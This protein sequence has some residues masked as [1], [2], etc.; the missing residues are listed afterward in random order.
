M[1]CDVRI[2]LITPASPHYPAARRLRYEVLRRPLGRPEGSECFAHEHESLH[3]VALRGDEVVGCVMF[4]PQGADT[5]RLLQMAVSP[6]WQGR[7]VGRLLVTVLE[8]EVTTR[9]IVEVTLH[10]RAHVTAFYEK[11][12]YEAYGEPYEEVG[13]AHRSMRKTLCVKFDCHHS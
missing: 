12:G 9:G 3:F 11:L 13:I 2:S 5:G 8:R 6:A 1:A 4:Y 10:A 7:G